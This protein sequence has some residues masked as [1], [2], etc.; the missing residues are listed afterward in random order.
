M[1]CW[2]NVVGNERGVHTRVPDIQRAYLS[3]KTHTRGFMRILSGVCLLLAL[4]AQTTQAQQAASS[5]QEVRQAVA[6]LFD[7]MRARDTAALRAVFDS[8]ARLVTTFN[9]NGAP[10]TDV[11]PANE[12][13]GI[14]ATAAP[15]QLLDERI[16]GTEVKVE[17]NLASVWT[18]YRFYLG[19][20]LSHCG[21]DAFL[22]AK[23]SEGW[24]IIAVADTRRMGAQCG[25]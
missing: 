22:L 19:S 3:R 1:A 17:D 23:T 10:V 6:R 20:Q 18:R 11:T 14:V 12:F 4:S 25:S 7:G 9:R 5:E 21:I 8:N 24:K 16:E 15:G 2:T 13:I